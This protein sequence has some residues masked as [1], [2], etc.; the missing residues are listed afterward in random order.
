MGVFLFQGGQLV[1]SG[2]EETGFS[3]GG[4]LFERAPFF[5]F[6]AG[7][8]SYSSGSLVGNGKRGDSA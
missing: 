4:P 8:D 5:S 7:H 2:I 6:F 1:K 3:L